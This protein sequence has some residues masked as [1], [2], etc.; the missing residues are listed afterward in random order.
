MFKEIRTPIDDKDSHCSTYHGNSIGRIIHYVTV[1]CGLH[2]G[3]RVQVGEGKITYPTSVHLFA[4]YNWDKGYPDI[5]FMDNKWNKIKEIRL[6]KYKSHYHWLEENLPVFL[7]RLNIDFNSICPGI[8]SAHG[9]K[10]YSYR[11]VWNKHGIPFEHGMAI[12]L[13]S[14]LSPFSET[15][16]DTKTGWVVPCLWVL[17]KHSELAHLLPKPANNEL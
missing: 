17:E 10:G 6:K 2:I 7:E 9:D 14:Y 1:I 4:I 5:T 13:L 12:Y 3:E 16:R 8:I 15:V 11:N